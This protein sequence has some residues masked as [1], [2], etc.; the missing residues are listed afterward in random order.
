MHGGYLHLC[1]MKR[2]ARNE[3]NGTVVLLLELST[4]EFELSIDIMP[5]PYV[6]IYSDR[7]Q[8]YDAF[9]AACGLVGLGRVRRYGK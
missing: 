9:D 6:R 4:G 7:T 1:E 8:A 3:I 2:I 5:S